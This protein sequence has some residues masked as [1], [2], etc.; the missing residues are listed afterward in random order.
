MNPASIYPFYTK[1]EMWEESVKSFPQDFFQM[2]NAKYV[3]SSRVFCLNIC[4]NA[5]KFSHQNHIFIYKYSEY[6]KECLKGKINSY[7]VFLSNQIKYTLTKSGFSLC[8]ILLFFCRAFL[9]QTDKK[10]CLNP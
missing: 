10:H 1:S 2:K 7:G 4:R 6:H 5:F 9:L 8:F 3:R